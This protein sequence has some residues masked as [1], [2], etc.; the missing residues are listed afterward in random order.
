M[1][2]IFNFSQKLSIKL[3]ILVSV[4]I[5]SIIS[6]FILKYTSSHTSEIFGFK[7]IRAEK[8]FLWIIIGSLLFFFIQFIRLRFFHEKINLMYIMMLVL[9][10]LPFFSEEVKG[11]QNWIFGFQPSEICKIIIVMVLAKFLSDN[12]RN[13]NTFYSI[14]ISLI[15]VAVPVIILFIQKDIGT[16]LI[17]LSIVLPMLYW[18]GLSSFYIFLILSPIISMYVS[19]SYNIYNDYSIEGGFPIIFLF[20]WISSILLV[21]MKLFFSDININRYKYI[22][23]MVFIN[24]G[25]VIISDQAWSYLNQEDANYMHIKRRIENFV[26]PALNPHDGGW[27]VQQSMVAVGS[28]GVFGLGLGEGHQV[29]GGFLREPDTDFIISNISETFGF[30]SIFLIILIYLFLIYWLLNYAEKCKKNFFSLVIIGY[31]S[32]LLFHMLITLGMAV[33][34]APITGVPAPFLSYGGTFTLSCFAML[35]ICNNISNN[36]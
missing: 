12:H 28:G 6:F 22:I 35:G 19:M 5:L 25:I 9:I 11:A 7:L 16:A 2:R 1:R 36:I 3:P 14:F 8:Q 15:I 26:V 18:A 24:V 4:I 29:K 23:I 32:I 17:Y 21:L 33:A 10:S 34:L 20:L 30:S 27:Q 31:L 13:I